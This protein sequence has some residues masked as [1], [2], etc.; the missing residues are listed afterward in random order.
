MGFILIG[1]YLADRFRRAQSDRARDAQLI[2]FFLDLARDQDGM[3]LVDA[4]RADVE[5]CLVDA[6]LHKVRGVALQDSHD[7][8]GY[9][10][11]ERMIP[12]C[13]DGFGAEPC[14][15][16]RRHS[17]VNAELSCFVGCG[18]Y[19]AALRGITA[20]D[21]GLSA[22][23]GMF[24]LFDGGEE[25]IEVNKKYRAA[26][27]WGKNVVVRG[28]IRPCCRVWIRTVRRIC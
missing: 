28:R 23:C 4:R 14:C 8:L 25:R 13:P 18:R 16:A 19:H 5:E 15:G 10:F 21:D 17:G 24:A 1:C 22:P 2:D 9:L 12:V 3:S 20:N 7:L 26:F 6:H 11:V 27:P